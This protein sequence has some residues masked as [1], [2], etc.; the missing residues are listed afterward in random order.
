VAGEVQGATF[1]GAAR[2]TGEEFVVAVEANPSRLR[3][4]GFAGDAREH[5]R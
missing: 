3:S 5:K 4:M 2:R 1:V